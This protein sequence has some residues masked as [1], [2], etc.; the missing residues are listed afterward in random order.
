MRAR[1]S[2]ACRGQAR[3][4]LAGAASWMAG[5]GG[6]V[7]SGARS[8]RQSL[9]QEQETHFS[10]GAGEGFSN[11]RYYKLGQEQEKKENANLLP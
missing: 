4:S 7:R 1:A 6:G 10:L 8:R 11:K 5:A 2:Q 9:G 3:A